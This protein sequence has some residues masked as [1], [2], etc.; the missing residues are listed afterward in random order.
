MIINTQRRGARW[1]YD[2]RRYL[3]EKNARVRAVC[4]S[5]VA[6]AGNESATECERGDFSR[7]CRYRNYA[8]MR[9]FMIFFFFS[10]FLSFLKSRESRTIDA[11]AIRA[12]AR[13]QVSQGNRRAAETWRVDIKWEHCSRFDRILSLFE[14]KIKNETRVVKFRS[15]GWIPVRNNKQSP[16]MTSYCIYV[17]KR[18]TTVKRKKK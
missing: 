11:R 8:Q 15:K 12:R 7:T 14:T 9:I 2:G 17:L 3:T 6:R 10:C 5:A 13:P 1:I 4:S 18:V 16:Q